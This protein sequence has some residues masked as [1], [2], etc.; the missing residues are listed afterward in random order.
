MDDTLPLLLPACCLD[1][2]RNE[3]WSGLLRQ[4]YLSH[5]QGNQGTGCLV[6][7]VVVDFNIGVVYIPCFYR[8]RRTSASAV[9]GTS[10]CRFALQ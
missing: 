4:L 7:C 5:L 9:D 10:D 6:I 8:R 2:L 1:P 3:D